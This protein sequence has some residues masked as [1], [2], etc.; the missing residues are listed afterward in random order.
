MSMYSESLLPRLEELA[1]RAAE[2]AGVEVAWVEFKSEG[3]KWFLRVFID[4]ESG[5]GLEDCEQVSE[6][7]GVLLD[8][9]DPI[10]SSYTLEVSTPGLDRP[11]WNKRDYERFAGRLARIQTSEGLEGRQRF[12]GRLAGVEMDD[13]LLVED[14]RQWRIPVSM[15]ENGRLEVELF[16]KKRPSSGKARK[17]S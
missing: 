9:E 13:V 16:P 12:R 8:V 6:R 3:P 5:V 1:R 14:G 17:H 7:L 15:I 4:R 10:E 11:L 2:P